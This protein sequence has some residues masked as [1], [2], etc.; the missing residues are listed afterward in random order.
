MQLL[1][2]TH[3]L[4]WAVA[5]SQ[6]LPVAV[7]EVLEDPAND[8]F[9]SAASIWEIA[10]KTSLG[11][12]DFRIRPEVVAGAAMAAQ[13]QALPVDHT[14]AGLVADLPPLHQDPFDRLLIAQAMAAP[15]RFY[16]A[17][18]KLPPYSDLVTL[19]A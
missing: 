1:L 3:I 6:R 2:D 13:F 17:D 5:D 10:I 14:A 19:V 4:L 18:R 16:T 8:V 15:M 11:R 12:P 7:R 9:F